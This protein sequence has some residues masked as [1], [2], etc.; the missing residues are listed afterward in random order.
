M[1]NERD[2]MTLDDV[3]LYLQIGRRTVRA[4]HL[5]LTMGF[6]SVTVGQVVRVNKSALDKWL[7]E[8]G[9]A[10][11]APRS[12]TKSTGSAARVAAFRRR[13]ANEAAR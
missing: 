10:G 11:R 3:A 6:P 5:D 13:H 4:W 12:S 9:Q 7:T 1:S 2:W 8:H